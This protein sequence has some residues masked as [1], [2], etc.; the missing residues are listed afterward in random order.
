MEQAILRRVAVHD[1][2]QL[3]M[4]LGYPLVRGRKTRYRIDTFIFVP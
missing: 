2:F 3:E 4:K 1:R